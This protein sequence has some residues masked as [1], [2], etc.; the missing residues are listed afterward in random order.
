VFLGGVFGSGLCSC[1][2]FWPVGW[3]FFTPFTTMGW[4]LLGKKLS[5]KKKKK[6]IPYGDLVDILFY[7]SSLVYVTYGP[8]LWVYTL[9]K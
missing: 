5:L 6:K 1:Q 4:R 9:Y 8:M 2:A 3:V 7:F